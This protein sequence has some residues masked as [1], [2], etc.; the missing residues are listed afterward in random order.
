MSVSV[1]VSVR[2]CERMYR[3]KIMELSLFCNI[4][5]DKSIGDD[6]DSTSLDT[7]P[8]SLPHSTHS[9][10]DPFVGIHRKHQPELWELESK[11]KSS[12]PSLPYFTS[13]RR[14]SRYD[15]YKQQ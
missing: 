14:R 13:R 6:E 15:E 9:N 8:S 4:S 10:A 12:P 3:N 7:P 11:S 1:S 2:V 5:T